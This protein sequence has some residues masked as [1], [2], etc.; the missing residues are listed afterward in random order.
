M[1]IRGMTLITGYHCDFR[2]L[3]CSTMSCHYP[4][5]IEGD[6]QL[7]YIESIWKN[8]IFTIIFPNS[9][10]KIVVYG[11]SGTKGENVIVRISGFG[12]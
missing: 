11:P 7:I 6:L 10:E 8:I 3:I 2:K 4:T 9:L 5:S 1:K 12:I